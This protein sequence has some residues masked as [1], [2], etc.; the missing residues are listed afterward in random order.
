MAP[1]FEASVYFTPP[2]EDLRFL[3]ECPR[4]LRNY[5]DRGSK[6]GWVAIQHAVGSHEGSIN[7]LDLASGSNESFPLRG[8]PGFIAETTEPGVVLVG[9]EQQLAYFNLCTGVLGD[10]IARIPASRNVIINDGLAVDGGVLFGTKDVQ[11]SEP[12]A[13]LYYLDFATHEVRPILKEQI[14]SNGKFL[15]RDDEGATLID[16]D[17]K[18]KRISRYRL[19][20]KLE[21]IIESSLILSPESLSAFPDGLRPAPAYGGSLEGESM[22]VAYYNPGPRSN[23]L[24]QQVRLDDGAVLCEWIVPGAPR[25]TCPEFVE[26][27]GKVKVLFT[28]AVEGMPPEI[29]R[30][31]PASGCIFIAETPFVCGMPAPPPLVPAN[32]GVFSSK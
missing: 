23:G 15:C 24:G 11:F 13:A 8:R 6:L 7:V 5:P 17:S 10:T 25:V 20:S 9:F 32:L 3:P 14:C 22:L 12:I 1:R 19:D 31:A 18:P 28:T 4:I 26:L 21:R 2:T 29:R 30:I 27:D 16:V